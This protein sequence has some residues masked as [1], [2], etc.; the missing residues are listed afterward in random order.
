MPSNTHMSSTFFPGC[1]KANR[2]GTPQ[3]MLQ[4]AS[5]VGFHADSVGCVGSRV[6]L[7]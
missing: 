5:G 6:G 3:D 4:Y 1:R 2:V 7:I